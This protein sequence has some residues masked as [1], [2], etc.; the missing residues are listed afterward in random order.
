MLPVAFVEKI[1]KML[2]EAEVEAFLN[3]Y[4]DTKFQALRMNQWKL[5]NRNGAGE[6]I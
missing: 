5:A 6:G 2:P 1:K 3:S 4:E